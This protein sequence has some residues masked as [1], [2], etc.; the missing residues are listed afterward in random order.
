MNKIKKWR[1]LKEEDVS[2][3][4][5]FPLYKHTVKLSSGKIIDDYYFWYGDD[6]DLAWRMRLLGWKEN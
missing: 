2:P 6:L 3:S 1:L 5:W 4:R